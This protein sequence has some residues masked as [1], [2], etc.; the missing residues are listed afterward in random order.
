MV[1]ASNL[2]KVTLQLGWKHQFQYAGFYIAKEQGFYQEVELDVSLKEFN[3][4]INI[5][6]D[7][8]SGHVNFGIGKSSL[9]IER[10]KGVPIIALGALY[11]S[12]PSVLIT[13]N[14]F[15]K[16]LKDIRK[17]KIMVTEDAVRSAS[18]TSM[19]LS[20]G[21]NG[22]DFFRQK[23]SFNYNDLIEGHTDAMACYLPNEPFHLAKKN[24]PYQTFNPKDY[25]YDFYGDILYTSENEL[26]NNPERVRE[27]YAASK[28]GWLW[29]FENIEETAQLIFEKYNTQN[30]S[31]AS[32]IYEGQ[33]LKKLALVKGISFGHISISKFNQIAEVF[34]LGN[35]LEKEGSLN[36]FVDPLN[37]NRTQVKIGILAERGIET[38]LKRWTPLIQYLN[39]KLE[40]HYF[41][42]IPLDYNELSINISNNK[43]DFFVTNTLNYVQ[44]EHLYGASR[45]ATLLNHDSLTQE[46]F[47][48]YGGVIFTKIDNQNINSIEDIRGKSFAGVDRRSFGGWIMAYDELINHGISQDDI[49]LTFL[50]THD[51]VV[52]AVL[53]GDIE[54][55]TIRTDTLERMAS[56]GKL[57]LSDIKIVNNKS[58]K[59]FPYLVSTQLYP[60]WPFSKLKNTSNH[61]ANEVLSALLDISPAHEKLKEVQADEWTVPLNYN[62]VHELLKKLDIS[63]YDLHEINLVDVFKKYSLIVYAITLGFLLLIFRLLYIKKLNKTLDS[64]NFKLDQ[65][66]KERTLNLKKANKKLKLFARTDPLTGINNRA[67]FF[68]KETSILV[69]L[70]GIKHPCIYLCLI[71]TFLKVLTINMAI[72]SEI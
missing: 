22:N 6:N 54:S 30:K 3:H 1:K 5:V 36:T 25:G 32:L 2:E 41:T 68:I 13:T 44:L 15:I 70:L 27:F 29:A 57:K 51:A 65:L 20:S 21:I 19:L 52:E 71:W 26:V 7:V 56:E 24:I 16:S 40:H 31:L 59:G 55:G 67:I 8:V 60:E 12:S 47:S 61:L 49:K 33:V 72:I 58:N 11:Q 50:K 48:R 35:M 45:I 66:V 46:K 10:Y 42:I 14:P 43:L 39:A 4:S 53:K 63:P 37:L 23:H 62:A 9:L 38:T 69:S 18:I 28:K 64:Y 34:R 17:K